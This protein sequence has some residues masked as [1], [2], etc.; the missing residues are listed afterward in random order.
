MLIDTF[1]SSTPLSQVQSN[2]RNPKV[3]TRLS[4]KNTYGTSCCLS[5]NECSIA[6]LVREKTDLVLYSKRGGFLKVL[7]FFTILGVS[8]FIVL[9]LRDF[10][11]RA[12]TLLLAV[13]FLYTPLEPCRIRKLVIDM[14]IKYVI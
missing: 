5:C 8:F 1:S 7:R 14:F 3:S 4:T 6:H 9:K 11:I 10:L 12:V 2:E 13:R